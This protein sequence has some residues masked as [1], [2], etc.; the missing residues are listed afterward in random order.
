MCCSSI[1]K[2]NHSE[3]DAASG[4]PFLK[5]C[6]LS[7][8]VQHFEYFLRFFKCLP[9]DLSI[10]NSRRTTLSVK[11]FSPSGSSS[12]A[13]SAAPILRSLYGS[14][15]LIDFTCLF[16]SL[17]PKIWQR[18]QASASLSHRSHHPRRGYICLTQV[19]GRRS[20]ARGRRQFQRTERERSKSSADEHRKMILKGRWYRLEDGAWEA[21]CYRHLWWVWP[22]ETAAQSAPMLDGFFLFKSKLPWYIAVIYCYN[23]PG[24]PLAAR[25]QILC[26]FSAMW[27]LL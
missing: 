25:P 8:W 5:S 4:C 19:K 10:A 18:D 27:S 14:S 2:S 20:N 11:S 15:L 1:N 22:V 16:A 12:H 6:L 23:S 21:T 3:A 24:C 7:R 17:T 13:S 26:T 9:A